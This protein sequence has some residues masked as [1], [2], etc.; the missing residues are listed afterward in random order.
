MLDQNECAGMCGL[1]VDVVF[2]NIAYFVFFRQGLTGQEPTSW[3]MLADRKSQEFS[4][5]CLPSIGG[6]KI[7]PPYLVCLQD[8]IWVLMLKSKPFNQVVCLHLP[9]V[10]AKWEVMGNMANAF[11]M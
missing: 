7:G 2:M 4:C 3:T 10:A 9:L 11:G 8:W 5:F 1:C 6:A